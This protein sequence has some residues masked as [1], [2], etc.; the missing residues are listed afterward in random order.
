MKDTQRYCVRKRRAQLPDSQMQWQPWRLNIRKTLVG[1]V[2]QTQEAEYTAF[3][4]IN[5]R[6]IKRTLKFLVIDG[7]NALPI[8]GVAAITKFQLTIE[9]DGKEI[10]IWQKQN[11]QTK[12]LISQQRLGKKILMSAI[13]QQLTPLKDELQKLLEKYEDQFTEKKGQVGKISTEQCH[14]SLTDEKPINCRPYPCS[15]KDQELIDVQIT[16]LLVQGLV[17]PSNSN[18]SFPVV[19]VDKRTMKRNHDCA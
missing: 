17:E 10:Q 2:F 7:S 1:G 8:I 4:Q 19:L 6:K 12:I 9:S 16:S 18:Y 15:T 3:I 5:T 14:I 13:N 11:D